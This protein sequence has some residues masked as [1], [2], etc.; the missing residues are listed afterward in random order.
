MIMLMGHMDT[1]PSQLPVRQEGSILHGRGTVDAKGPLA[2]MIAAASAAHVPGV[3]IVVAGVVEEETYGRGATHLGETFS[4]QAAF[5]GEPN[6]WAG[7][8]I[9]YKGRVM[10]RYSVSRP[11]VHT[12]SPEEKASE[13]AVAFWNTITAYFE[14]LTVGEKV[15]DRPVATL[16]ELNATI[17][18]A[19]AVISCRIPPGFDL[20]AFEDVVQAAAGDGVLV[21]DDRTPRCG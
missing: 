17:E 19:S 21:I 8:G 7:V 1:V 15:F 10:L 18:Q 13:A 11:S 2:A 14:H 20:P 3:Q 4:P 12:A 5:V 9:G 6:G 16:V